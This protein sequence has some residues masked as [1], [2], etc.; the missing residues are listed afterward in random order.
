MNIKYTS[1]ELSL[2]YKSNRIGW[3]S[4]Y[5]SEKFILEKI[6]ID[7]TA[8]VLD[9]GCACGGLGVA[10]EEQYDLNYY[11]GVDIN[12]KCIEYAKKICPWGEFE[13]ADFLDVYKQYSTDYD[14]GVSLSCADWN[15]DTKEMLEALFSRIKPGGKLIFSCRLTNEVIGDSGV[16]VG[17]QRICWGEGA[18][19]ENIEFAPYKVFT[20]KSVLNL[21]LSI[22]FV[23][24]V[25]GYGYWGNVPETVNNI[26]LAKVHY[27]V[28][29][30]QKADT[31]CTAPQINLNVDSTFWV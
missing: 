17:R 11:H 26:K 15:V 27:V 4:L 23:S 2:F 22:G 3:G 8:Q 24:K 16:V 5:P 6:N 30:I 19:P 9:M 25:D 7:S 20:L 12:L 28:F 21:L 14:I 1:D 13:N 29:A 10:L 18:D 31:Q